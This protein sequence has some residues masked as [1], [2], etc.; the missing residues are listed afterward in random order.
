MRHLIVVDSLDKHVRNEK[1]FILALHG[2]SAGVG[3]LKS[4]GFNGRRTE[5]QNGGGVPRLEEHPST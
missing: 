3:A 4:R 1:G 2:S 5:H